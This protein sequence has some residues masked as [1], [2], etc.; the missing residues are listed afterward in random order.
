MLPASVGFAKKDSDTA[1]TDNSKTVAN[2]ARGQ[3]AYFNAW[4]C[5]EHINAYMQWA[6]LELQRQHGVQLQHV[7]I[8]DATDVVKRF[9]AEK[10]AGCDNNGPAPAASATHGCRTFMAPP[11]ATTQDRWGLGL[12]LALCAKEIP[13]M[14]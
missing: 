11:W 5:S 9:R 8:S 6:A 1:N 7:K 3:T 14:R 10:S 4:A 2:A 13:F 12:I